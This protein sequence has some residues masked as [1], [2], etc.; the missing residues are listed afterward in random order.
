[1]NKE[2]YLLCPVCEKHKFPKWEDNGTCICPHCGCSVVNG[3]SR[4]VQKTE[5]P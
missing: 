3:S 4:K 5:I 1:M 2:T